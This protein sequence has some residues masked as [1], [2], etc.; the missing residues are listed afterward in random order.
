MELLFMVAALRTLSPDTRLR[1]LDDKLLI[2]DSTWQSA[3]ND[4]SVRC[5]LVC[6]YGLISWSSPRMEGTSD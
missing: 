4:R 3:S 6:R 5:R 1:F 2:R